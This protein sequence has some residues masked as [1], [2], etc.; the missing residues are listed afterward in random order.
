MI[1][2]VID[3]NVVLDLWLF[4]DPRTARLRQALQQ[5]E[6]GC[7]ATA[8]M[9]EELRR[10]LAYPHLVERLNFYQ[11]SAEQVLAQYVAHARFVE[12]PSKAPWTC[13]DPD[14]QV[15]ID[16]AVAHQ[17]ALISKD[18]AVLALRGRLARASVAVSREWA[19]STATP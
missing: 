7:L 19:P 10:V 9:R 17:C 4:Q 18:K 11:K 5:G 15:F 8:H 16:L 12:A 13:K 1:H 2:L 3:T 6:V 14:D